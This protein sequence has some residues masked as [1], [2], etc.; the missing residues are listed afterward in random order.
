MF[1]DLVSMAGHIY[2]FGIDDGLPQSPNA[3]PSKISI[4]VH[5]DEFNELIGDEFIPLINKGGGA[6]VQVTAY[7]QTISDIKA[8]IGDAAKAGQIVGNFN[9]MVMLRV[10]EQATAEVLTKNLHEVTIL[11]SM[12]ISSVTDS[13]D[14]NSDKDFG[15]NTGHRV[16][17]KQKPMLSPADITNLPKGQAFALIEGS[18][19]WKIRMP[20]PIEDKD[21]MMPANL[22]QL[23][24][25]MRENYRTTE[26]WW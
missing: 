19:L 11:E 24:Q 2:K 8:R 9:S 1:A 6:G 13:N 26:T 5:C 16:T 14:P 17:A 12:A 22:Q 20:L 21:D 25:S 23:A 7:T 4:N 15:S 3:K 18:Q 10:K